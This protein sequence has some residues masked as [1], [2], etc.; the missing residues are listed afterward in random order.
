ML[1]MMMM[2]MTMM[3]MMRLIFNTRQYT[4]EARYMLSPVNLSV[5]LSV[6]R[7]DQS[8]TVEVRIMQLSPQSSPIPLV[9]AE[10]V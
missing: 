3:M 4:C 2:T 10:Q 8:K 5:C 6:T 7:L 9:F 1:L